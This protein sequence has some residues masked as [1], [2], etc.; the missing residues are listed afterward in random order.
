[1]P[2]R[3]AWLFSRP[4]H[5]WEWRET[6]EKKNRENLLNATY[7]TVLA[8]CATVHFETFAHSTDTLAALGADVDVTCQSGIDYNLVRKLSSV[9]VQII[10][11]EM[12][13]PMALHLSSE[14]QSHALP[15]QPC[16]HRHLPQL[17]WPLP[18]HNLPVLGSRSHEKLS[19][20]QNSPVTN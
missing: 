8:E 12:K 2:T 3:P 5:F 14:A 16:S 1:M 17:Q 13:Q 6:R 18:E 20:S 11:V 9:C 19:H 10:Y 4:P 15:C 7:W